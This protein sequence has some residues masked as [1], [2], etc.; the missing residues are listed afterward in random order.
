MSRIEFNIELD[1]LTKDPSTEIFSSNDIDNKIL[2][3][4]SRKP[5][6][7]KKE[8]VRWQ[9]VH[10]RFMLNSYHG[11]KILYLK[12][13]GCKPARRVVSTDELFDTLERLHK[14]EADHTGRTR[15][16]ERASQEQGWIRLTG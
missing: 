8:T 1:S 4:N 16:Y 13:K 11:S 2:C 6:G 15:L 14:I 7:P 5:A 3:L 9:R 12:G 10:D